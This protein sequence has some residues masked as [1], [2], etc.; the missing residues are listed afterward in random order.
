M[1]AN[2]I[3]WPTGKRCAV[4]FTWDVDADSG[5]K[6]AHKDAAD[7]LVATQSFVRYG[8][9]IAVPRLIELFRKLE[10]RLTFFIPGWVIERYPAAV[11]LIVKN[12]HE[13]GLHGYLHEKSNQITPEQEAAVLD[14]ALAAYAKQIGGRPRGWRAPGFAFSKFSLDLLIDAGFDYDSSLMGNDIP[15]LIQG[16]RGQLV[17]LPTDWTLDDW[18][19]YMHNKDFGFVMPISA[20]ARAMEVFRAEFDAAHTYGAMWISVWHPFLS[21]RLAKLHAIVDLIDHMRSR[22]GVWFARLDEICDHVRRLVAEGTWNP[23]VERIPAGA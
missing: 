18:P 5:L 21:G 12:G 19:Y 13:V 16:T 6:Y 4:A 23:S 22:D 8:P 17:E 9:A 10:M 11:E 15:H 1:I 7:N 3:P 20:P 2:P 14:K